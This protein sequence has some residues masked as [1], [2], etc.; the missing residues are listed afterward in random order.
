MDAP[1][2]FLPS[3]IAIKFLPETMRE[4]NHSS[5]LRIYRQ[6][7]H[8]IRNPYFM[9]LGLVLSLTIGAL[10]VPFSSLPEIFKK[11]GIYESRS[12]KGFHDEPLRGDRS[13]QRSVR[14]NHKYRLFYI[15]TEGK[16]QII[17]IIEIN[18]HEN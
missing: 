3:F 16:I 17:T 6:F 14:L 12:I 11:I 5:F 10:L 15:L 9:T 8:M 18:N 1:Y 7:I 2:A 13:G 4:E